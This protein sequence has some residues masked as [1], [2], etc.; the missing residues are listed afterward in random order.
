MA[1]PIEW[2]LLRPLLREAGLENQ[3]SDHNEGTPA[4]FPD[5]MAAIDEY[6]STTE[7]MPKGSDRWA[8]KRKAIL[9]LQVMAAMKGQEPGALDGYMGP[10][11][12]HALE[13]VEAGMKGEPEWQRPGEDEPAEASWPKQSEV[14]EFYGEVGQHQVKLVLPYPMKLAWN[15]RSVVKSFSCHEKV[16]D[17]M[18]TIFEATLAHYG[19]EG[20]QQL[21]LDLFGGCLNVRRMR[22]GRAMSM[23]SWGIAVDLDPERNQLKW[24]R[25]RAAFAKSD[26]TAFWEIVEGQGATSLGRA[27]NYDW[28]HLQFAYL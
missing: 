12:R 9:A 5:D 6:I 27:R 26:Y 4:G 7:G 18:A 16:H 19:N 25:D 24:G 3:P 21:R 1:Q 14:P 28:M 22:G 11:T 8:P 2:R 13:A 20:I 10:Q 15:T 17:A 23:H